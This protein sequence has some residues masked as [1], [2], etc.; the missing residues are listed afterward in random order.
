MR[1]K[2]VLGATMK[3][4]CLPSCGV[5][6]MTIVGACFRWSEWGASCSGDDLAD[7]TKSADF[8]PNLYMINSGFF[9]LFICIWN[10]VSIGI[11]LLCCCCCLLCMG[12]MVAAA[13]MGKK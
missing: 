10:F 1:N 6:V 4:G 11:C 5:L 3:F 2:A 12:S 13:G 9:M 8:L 7:V